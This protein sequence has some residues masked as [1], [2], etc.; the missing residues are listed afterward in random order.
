MCFRDRESLNGR[1]EGTRFSTRVIAM[2]ERRTLKN[3]QSS[4][5]EGQEH[6]KNKE[7]RT[8]G[9]ERQMESRPAA[10]KIMMVS[11]KGT[12]G[13]CGGENIVLA[14]IGSRDH[15]GHKCCSC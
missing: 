4:E 13:S 14:Y 11:K 10:G 2:D 5:L 1:F 7:E 3:L 9:V 6:Q 15:H 12:R 8:W